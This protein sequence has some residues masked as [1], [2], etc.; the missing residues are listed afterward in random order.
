MIGRMTAAALGAFESIANFIGSPWE[1]IE[2]LR[3]ELAESNRLLAKYRTRAGN[4]RREL[5]DQDRRRKDIC[6][7]HVDSM[8][9]MAGRSRTAD[10]G[11]EQIV[12]RLSTVEGRLSRIGRAVR[13]FQD[14]TRISPTSL[15]DEIEGILSEGEDGK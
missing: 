1:H 12:K 4:Q 6:A 14:G 3:A 10:L 7:F 11:R 15:L 8:E 2:D 13:G 9:R 5:R